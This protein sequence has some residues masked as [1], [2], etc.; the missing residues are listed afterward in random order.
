MLETLVD[1]DALVDIYGK[2]AINQIECW[3]ADGVPVWGW[4]VESA[5]LDLL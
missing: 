2:H 4:V 5:H 3:I 1:G